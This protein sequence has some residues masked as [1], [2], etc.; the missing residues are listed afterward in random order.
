MQVRSEG[1]GRG[2]RPQFTTELPD[3]AVSPPT[4]TVLG[5]TVQV[6]WVRPG[7][8]NSGWFTMSLGVF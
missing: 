6:K 7:G 3:L 4:W 5:L 1:R 8:K 2:G